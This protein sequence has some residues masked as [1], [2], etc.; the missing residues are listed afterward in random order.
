[1]VYGRL[2]SFVFFAVF[3][4]MELD[5]CVYCFRWVVWFLFVSL[6]LFIHTCFG[7]CGVFHGSCLFGDVPL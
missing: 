3:C 2:V 7:A 1:M 6:S 5:M 4:A